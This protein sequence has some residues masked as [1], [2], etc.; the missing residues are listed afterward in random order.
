MLYKRCGVQIEFLIKMKI[1]QRS[2]LIQTLSI[3]IV[4]TELVGRTPT[5]YLIH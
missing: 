4:K 3:M 5:N 1:E 2:Q